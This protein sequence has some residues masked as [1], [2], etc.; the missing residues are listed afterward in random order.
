MWAAIPAIL[1]AVFIT[2]RGGL[3][4]ALGL[5]ALG[6]VALHELYTMMGRAR[7]VNVA[8]F[9]A[10]LALVLAALYG[11]QQQMVLV[12]V[13]AIPLT[14]AFA[15][16]RARRQDVS[17]SLA[18][19]IFG[20]AWIGMALAH[21]VLIRELPHGGGLVLDIAIA[22]FIG[23]T[24]AYFGG[25]AY[26]SRPIAPW[27]SPNK[28]LEGLIAGVVGGTFAFWLFAVAYQHDW[29]SGP[30]ALL[31]GFCVALAAPIGDLFESMI[32]RD[33]DVK[34]AGSFFGAHGGVLDRL[35]GLLFSAVVGYY[36]ASVVLGY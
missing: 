10:T 14:F 36:V 4:F 8:G 30:D 1:F 7:P 27:I 6:V 16:L 2:S 33:L 17:W 18:A 5:G 24:A 11:D 3:I 21:A 35:D 23:D 9:I 20:V 31:I 12:L 28:T 29:F 13:A 15:V 34:D 22:T 25:R 19:T 26:G 32:K